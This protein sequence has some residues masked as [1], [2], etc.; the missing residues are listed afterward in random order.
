MLGVVS[1]VGF[2]SAR[3]DLIERFDSAVWN[4][5]GERELQ[6]AFDFSVQQ[7]HPATVIN[8]ASVD[9]IITGIRIAQPQDSA[10]LMDARFLGLSKRD[11]R[12][13]QA[14]DSAGS[15]TLAALQ[16]LADSPSKTDAMINTV[17]Q[18]LNN[19][20][21]KSLRHCDPLETAR[22]L[23][24]YGMDSLA[25]IEFRNFVKSEFMVELTTIEVINAR[26]LIS[27]SE[28]IIKYTSS[29]Q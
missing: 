6:K 20:L 15:S 16:L 9:L 11:G 5:I 26:S 7:Q 8:S 27:L 1:D 13:F 3:H 22:P 10:L 12:A 29:N 17:L 24:D 14:A 4:R 21:M 19:Y 25:A 23:S 28:D 2:M 18:S